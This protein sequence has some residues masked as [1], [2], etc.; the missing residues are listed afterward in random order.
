MYSIVTLLKA[1]QCILLLRDWSLTQGGGGGGGGGGDFGKAVLAK[2][3]TFPLSLGLKLT[4]PPLI[5]G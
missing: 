2:H 3:V 1:M 4:D 5:R